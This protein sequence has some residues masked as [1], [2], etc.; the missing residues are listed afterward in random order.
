MNGPA[1][2]KARANR[3]PGGYIAPPQHSHSQSASP[4]R[5]SQC[6]SAYGYGRCNRSVH[7]NVLSLPKRRLRSSRSARE[8]DYA[9]D[10]AHAEHLQRLAMDDIDAR[11]AHED[12]Y[13]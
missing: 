9:V 10:A 4:S 5:R 7:F 2:A 6:G 11:Y 12:K 3:K 1:A 8:Q 13:V